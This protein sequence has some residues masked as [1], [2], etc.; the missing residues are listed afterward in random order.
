MTK[1]SAKKLLFSILLLYL[2]LAVPLSFAFSI[3]DVFNNVGLK[4]NKSDY[5]SSFSAITYNVDWAAGDI[6]T[7]GRGRGHS[8]LSLRNILLRVFMLAGITAATTAFAGSLF[9]IKKY[10]STYNAKNN[11][12]VKL[13]I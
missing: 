12:L 13:R 11:I 10:K 9:H 3:G 1:N 7:I 4:Q 2:A 5:V 8:V 6:A